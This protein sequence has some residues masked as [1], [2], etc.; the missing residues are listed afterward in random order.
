MELHVLDVSAAPADAVTVDVLARLQ[1]AARRRG[2][3]IA[4][5][6]AS[7]ELLDLVALMG[8]GDVLRPEPGQPV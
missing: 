1:L 7:G 5:R 8:L 2:C 6:N 3:A 4:L